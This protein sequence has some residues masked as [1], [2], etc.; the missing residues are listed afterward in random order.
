M[1]D[2]A[3]DYLG[4]RDHA[5]FQKAFSPSEGAITP[6]WAAAHPDPAKD[7]SMY[8]GAFLLPYGGWKEPSELARNVDTAKQLWETSENV[9]A[10][11]L[12]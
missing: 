3:A 1:T 8:A 4:S 5:S 11:V 10:A 12:D 7:R 9:L 6:L 2:G